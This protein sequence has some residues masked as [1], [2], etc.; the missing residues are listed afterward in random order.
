MVCFVVWMLQASH[1]M[2]LRLHERDVLGAWSR[3]RGDWS[4]LFEV[5]LQRPRAALL[6]LR[7]LQGRCAGKLEEE[8]EEGLCHQHR[9]AH[10]PCHSVL[11]RVCGLQAQQT[12]RQ[13]R[14]LWGDPDGEVAAEQDTLLRTRTVWITE[15]FKKLKQCGNE[16]QF[17]CQYLVDDGK[18]AWLVLFWKKISCV[19]FYYHTLLRLHDRDRERECVH[20][21]K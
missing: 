8:L 2:R 6:R 5:E 18:I 9:H 12:D 13:R 19:I 3:A 17:L 11:R 10:H 7:L 21:E 14:A 20:M 4:G 16:F 1:I 15:I